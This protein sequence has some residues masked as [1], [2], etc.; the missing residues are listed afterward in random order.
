MKM[1]FKLGMDLITQRLKLADINADLA[2]SIAA[3]Y[4]LKE[5]EV[6]FVRKGIVPSDLQFEEGERSVVSYITT[7]AVDRDQEIVE[8]KG[9]MLDDYRKNPVVL[10]CHDYSKLPIGKNVWIKSDEKGLIAKTT[11]APHEE[12]EK[13]YQYRKAGFPLAESIGFVPLEYKD[14]TAD[15]KEKNG[16]VRRTFS[17]WLL[18]EYSDVPVPSN[19]E[20]LMLAVSKGLIKTR[21]EPVTTEVLVKEETIWVCPYCKQVINEKEVFADGELW[22]HSPCKDAGAITLPKEVVEKPG[23]DE[24]DTAF[25]YRVRDPGL[26]QEGSFRTVA[27]KRDKPRVNS[28]MGKLQNQDT[29]T[30][31]NLMFPKEDDWTLDGAKTW[32]ADHKDLLK[33]VAFWLQIGESAKADTEEKVGHVLTSKNRELTIAAIAS[34]SAASAA[35]TG[36]LNATEELP[37]E[38][39]SVDFDD[40]LAGLGRDMTYRT[41]DETAIDVNSFKAEP[42]VS[43]DIDID[44]IL[45][46]AVPQ[47]DKINLD[48][49]FGAVTKKLQGKVL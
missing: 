39:E 26:F 37:R 3:E 19:P 13:V 32:L 5:D 16:G 45:N 47:V 23:W 12:A 7:G 15:E 41:G 18:L 35:L 22:Y 24:T 8:P 20:A 27:V 29:M 11:Y 46:L 2:K 34:M 17:K 44:A 21:I 31:Q 43:L 9:A 14:H 1:E 10:F 6:Q 48:E 28:V 49:L 42:E 4:K 30:V 40:E 25:R 38:E 36:L 33:A